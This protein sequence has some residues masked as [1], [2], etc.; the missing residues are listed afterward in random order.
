[1]AL[2]KKNRINLLIGSA[3]TTLVTLPTLVIVFGDVKQPSFLPGNAWLW[4]AMWL[5]LLGGLCISMVGLIRK[6][7]WGYFL[8]SQSILSFL[9]LILYIGRYRTDR[10]Y[11]K[12]GHDPEAIHQ[13]PPEASWVRFLYLVIM[14]LVVGFMPVILMGL[15]RRYKVR[16]S[17]SKQEEAKLSGGN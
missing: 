10:D 16:K 12:F 15:W 13:G 11:A 4:L 1:M 9:V 17:C 8:W 2:D 3:L 5:L 14:W 7:H 6:V